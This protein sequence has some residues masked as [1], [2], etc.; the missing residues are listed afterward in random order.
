MTGEDICE[1]LSDG[2]VKGTHT[3][4]TEKEYD[5]IL[6]RKSGVERVS[7]CNLSVNLELLKM[8]IFLEIHTE[9]LMNDMLLCLG[10][11]SKSLNR[12]V[13]SRNM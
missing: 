7:G 4:Y 12:E 13:V 10:F 3:H 11:P 1:F 8:E 6:L 5:K 9:V 2:L